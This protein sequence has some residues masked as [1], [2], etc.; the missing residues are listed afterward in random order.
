MS[1]V[2]TTSAE[3]ITRRDALAERL[4]TGLLE[5][6]ELLSVQLGVELGLYSGLRRDGPADAHE[7]AE[8]AGIHPR[9]AREWLEQQAAAGILDSTGGDADP[10]RRRFALPAGHAEALLDHDSPAAVHAVAPAVIGIASVLDRLATSYRTGGGV[11]YAAFGPDLRHGIAGMNRPLFTNDLAVWLAAAPT[12]DRHLRSRARP[13]ILD[14]GCGTGWSSVALARAYPEARVH[15]IDL[16]GASVDEARRNATEAGVDGRVD[17]EV[18]D[19]VTVDELDGRYDLV[20]IFEALHDMA[21][22]VRTLA[23]LG[24][25]LTEGG[26]V[27]VADE[28]VCETFT[29]PAEFNDRLMYAWSVLHCL[30]ATM[31]EQPSIATGT[32]LRP[33]TLRRYAAEAALPRVEEL[34]VD[35]DFW[36]LYL[37]QP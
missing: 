30:P 27:L 19:A 35:N 3:E 17:F 29:A 13:E 11:P 28:R 21:H 1:M 25:V 31:A 33:S 18:R 26:A 37:L 36:R 23:K 32:V 34:A 15:G 5:A 14:V 9:Y 24:R 8:R 16:D 22:P 12:V 2:S 6:L 4:F 20:C 7:L 10:E